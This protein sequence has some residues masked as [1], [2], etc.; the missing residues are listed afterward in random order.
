MKLYALLFLFPLLAA[1]E[2]PIPPHS[3]LVIAVDKSKSIGREETA[4]WRPIADRF[5]ACMASGHVSVYIIDGYSAT[6][7]PVFGRDVPV[8]G[9]RTLAC[10]KKYNFE[11]AAFK[12]ALQ[13]AIDS[14]FAGNFEAE[15]TDIFGIIDRAVRDKSSALVLETDG[16]ATETLNFEKTRVTPD[17]IPG[18]ARR[19]ASTYRWAGLPCAVWMVLPSSTKS[20]TGP[21]SRADLSA[22][23]SYLFGANLKLFD[24]HM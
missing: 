12:R 16:L 4:L 23:Y 2:C 7:A 24:D 21:N 3:N 8:Q 6:R 20:Q 9:C 15:K 18:L 17:A 5:L 22:F 19:V 11:I 14:T 1:A 13:S 10:K